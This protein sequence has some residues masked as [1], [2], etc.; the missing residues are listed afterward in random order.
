MK[1]L[2]YSVLM[3]LVALL[4][5]GADCELL[6]FKGESF[7][8]T[9]RLSHTYHITG[10]NANYV[11]SQ[12]YNL[13]DSLD[14]RSIDRVAVED[15][16]VQNIELVFTNNNPAKDA[17]GFDLL[18]AFFIKGGET[19]QHVV[20]QLPETGT[21]YSTTFTEIGGDPINPFSAEGQTKLGTDPAKLDVLNA[22]VSTIPTNITI[23]TSLT[24][25]SSAAR[26][27]DFFLEVTFDVQITYTGELPE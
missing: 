17:I 15:V 6:D 23:G 14:A 18:T 27:A 25:I 19:L 3:V 5:M 1:K 2:L 13:A 11:D 8:Y 26:P 12:S 21:G 20:A 24:G 4:M 7:L 9:V 22:Y 10:N 16:V